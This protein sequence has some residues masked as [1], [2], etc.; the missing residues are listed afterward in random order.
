MAKVKRNPAMAPMSGKIKDLHYAEYADKQVVRGGYQR[1]PTTQW[2]EPQTESQGQFGEAT[3]YAKKVV[4]DP[5]QKAKYRGVSKAKHRSEWNLAIAD[6]CRPPSILDVDVTEYHG[7]P[8]QPIIIAAVDDTQVAG[9]SLAIQT[10]AGALI[11]QG[12]AALHGESGRWIYVAQ[13]AAAD[14]QVAVAVEVTAVDLPGN[15]VQKRVDR[16]IRR[17]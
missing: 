11:E 10:A 6:A 5:V 13:A 1:K 3:K 16:I 2:T 17:G 12:P 9:V 15:R 7:Q 8:G 4:S 14:D